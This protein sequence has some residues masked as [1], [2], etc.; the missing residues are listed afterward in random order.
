[1]EVKRKRQK[2]LQITN[3]RVPCEKQEAY[4]LPKTGDTLLLP[5]SSNC[6]PDKRDAPGSKSAFSSC[7]WSYW[8]QKQKAETLSAFFS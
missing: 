7:F 8:K 6:S 5:A 3:W 4:L 2:R 1:M